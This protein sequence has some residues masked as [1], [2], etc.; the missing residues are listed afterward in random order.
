MSVMATGNVKKKNDL[1]PRETTVRIETWE[2]ESVEETDDPLKEGRL[3]R[4][5]HLQNPEAEYAI[6]SPEEIVF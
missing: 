2:I 3:R 5:P 6:I 4:L 1:P